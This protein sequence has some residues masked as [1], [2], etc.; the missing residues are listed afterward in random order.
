MH[1]LTCAEGERGDLDFEGIAIGAH[2]LIRSAHRAG[3]SFERAP[4]RI[5]ERFAG[6]EHGLF[7]DYAQA[8]HF[9]D[10]LQ[11]VGDGPVAADQLD[12]FLAL[13]RDTNGVFEYPLIQLGARVL[14]RVAREDFHADAVGDCFRHGR[15]GGSE[16]GEHERL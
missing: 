4:R 2:H 10:V 1:D 7:A 15:E 5:F 11:R 12:G 6:R 9:V 3:G 8:L 13:I 16:F 14:G